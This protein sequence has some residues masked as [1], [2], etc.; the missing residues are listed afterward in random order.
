MVVRVYGGRTNLTA[1]LTQFG[2]EG[3][4]DNFQILASRGYAV[5]LP[6][7]A[8]TGSPMLDL[9]KNILPGVSKVVE[10]GYADENRLGICGH[11]FGGYSTLALIVQ[12][13]RFRAAVAYAGISNLLSVWGDSW[14][15]GA[16]E[17]LQWLED[18]EG[19]PRMAGT[20]WQTRQAYIENSPFFYLDRV[21]T[22]LL[23]IHGDADPLPALQ[24]DQVYF[25][26]QRLGKTVEYARYR[27]AGHSMTDPDNELD[28]WRRLVA[29][30][31]KHLGP[32]TAL[33]TQ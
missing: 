2:L 14:D 12:T 13:R 11:S 31:D 17:S 29:W 18:P 21:T 26:L 15:D 24:S 25:A 19:Q 30:F 28:Y 22:P 7:S 32:A 5:F 20:P 16:S 23:L 6:E 27:N 33:A 10:L 4:S 8:M 3:R 9:A 1:N